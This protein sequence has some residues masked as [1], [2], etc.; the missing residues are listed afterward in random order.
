MVAH[1]HVAWWKSLGLV[2]LPSLVVFVALD[3]T[4]ITLFAGSVYKDV[5]GDYL[6][7]QPR[8]VP[9]LLAW[10]CIVGA[11]YLFALP[12]SRTP[13]GAARQG[14]LLGLGLYGCYEA[15]N[16]SILQR[17]TPAL[18]AVDTAWGC[19]ACAAAAVVQLLLQR[20]LAAA[21]GAG[22]GGAL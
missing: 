15:T 22:P 16:L 3:L 11:V 10:L 18:A 2:F 7:P 20:R 1:S 6:T 5:L 19:T 17:W 8:V 21:A 13:A 14:A 12:L 4:W 9:G